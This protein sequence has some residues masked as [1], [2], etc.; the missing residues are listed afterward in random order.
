MLAYAFQ[1]LRQ[2]NY[3]DV[4]SE[5]FEEVQ[6]LFA[7][8]L[9]RG[10]AQQLKQGLYREY[11]TR[12]EDLPTLRGKLNL[13]GTIRSQIQRKKL[14]SCEYDELSVNNV[15]NRILKTTAQ[16]LM[17]DSNVKQKNKKALKKGCF[18]LVKYMVSNRQ[19]SDGIFYSISGTI[20]TMRCS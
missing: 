8:I 3:E 2:K 20:K 7:A 16:I 11:I 15:F 4:A 10:I 5:E 1:V 19:R 12:N 17:R 6:D 18:S 9:A 14:L 13:Q